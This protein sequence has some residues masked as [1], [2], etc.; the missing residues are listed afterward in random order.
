MRPLLFIERDHEL[1]ALFVDVLEE[2]GHRVHAFDSPEAALSMLTTPGAQA[3]GALFAD[4]I[5]IDDFDDFCVE[6]RRRPRTAAVPIVLLST[7]PA[8]VHHV[9]RLS[10]AGLL[11]KPFDL[12]RLVDVASR[13][14]R[15]PTPP[16][17]NALSLEQTATRLQAFFDCPPE[18]ARA[19][20]EA[21][22]SPDQWPAAI[23]PG[24]R[25]RPLDG[26]LPPRRAREAMLIHVANGHT[27]PFHPHPRRERL[28]CLRGGLRDSDGSTLWAGETATHR[29]GSAHASATLG[30]DDCVVAVLVDD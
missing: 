14:G 15:E 27:F 4:E 26:E 9:P 11:V 20:A 18:S 29:P 6:L 28:L 19:I 25:V 30:D 22:A 12:E 3:P 23:G 10:L 2:S 17:M 21:S 7:R 24:I 1:R 16:A 5:S 8:A 13:L